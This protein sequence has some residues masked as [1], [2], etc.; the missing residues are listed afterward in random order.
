MF[1]RPHRTAVQTIQGDSLKFLFVSNNYNIFY[2]LAYKF[3]HANL[4]CENYTFS[5]LC[6]IIDALVNFERVMFGK[7]L[8]LN[9]LMNFLLLNS[10]GSTLQHILLQNIL[11][12]LLN[13]YY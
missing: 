8:L 4:L 7:S 13:K 10:D 11:G 3:A 5:S 9:G 1:K 12:Q 2:K 6:T